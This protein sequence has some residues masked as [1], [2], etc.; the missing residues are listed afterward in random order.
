MK[1]IKQF[2][3]CTLYLILCTCLVSAQ[4]LNVQSGSVLYQFP[5][6]QAGEMLYSNATTLTING[7]E[8]NLGNIDKMYVDN[9]AVT[10]NTVTVTY[11]SNSANV[12]VA[13]NIAQYV[14]VTVSGAQVSIIQ[15]ENVDDNV[16]KISYTLS[17]SS[18]NGGFYHEG[19]YKID[20]VLN[21][22]T[23]T[24]P[25]GPAINIQNGKKINVTVKAGTTNTLVDGSNGDW[26][27][28]F[29]VK[30][31]TELKGG[32]VLNITGKTA[33]AFWGKE[34]LEMKNCTL[35]I[36]GA[37]GDGINVNQHFSMESGTLNISGV[38]DN[39]LQVSY[40]TDDND[41]I[42][43]EDD[44]TGAITITGGTIN[45]TTTA[46]GS[47]GIKA[48]GAI[49]IS[50]LA[51]ITSVTVKT[52][53][54]TL[55]ET[56]GTQRDTSVCVCIKSETAISISGGT[57]TLTSTGQGGR[58]MTCDKTIDITGGTITARAEGSNYTGSS[59]S[60]G[61]GGGP[62]GGGPGG[63]GFGNSSSNGKNAK[64]VKAKGAITISG[65]TLTVYS[66]SHEGM[67]SKSTITITDGIVNVQASDDA[68]NATGDFTISGGYVYGY[69]SSNDGLD[70]NGNF[71]IKGGVAI[72]FGAGG[73]ES[74]I[75]TGESRYLIIS[76]GYAFG[77]GG[78]VDA[79]ISSS[80]TQAYCSGSSSSGGGWGGGSS[81][82][83]SISGSYAVV[84]QGTTRLFAV[85]MPKTSYSGAVFCSA[86]EMTKKTSY[87]IG[88]SSSVSGTETNGFI[89][90]PTVTS[91][92]G[93]T[94]LTAK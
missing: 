33:N 66:A 69:S 75:D 76:G 72:G 80:S 88:G 11:N 62:G 54:G 74:G 70:A 5:A 87:S 81:S 82:T 15:S 19:S 3:L 51:N 13:G 7:K 84:S 1:I 93:G 6:S 68:I 16:G 61:G 52:T 29:R 2:I 39:G 71:Y 46:S 89:K 26:K 58:A 59:S 73:A 79:S 31:H 24:N 91:V 86:P 9:S 50:E 41:K 21:G 64:G 63:G 28:C 25:S 17:G 14:D 30:G 48:E 65:G 90:S 77:I 8:F 49:Y 78:R 55:L 23:L 22:V 56:S 44:N 32:G 38:G 43:V 45:I 94:S 42:I 67:E 53:G 37:V 85:K 35:N 40:E 18:S 10:D 20:L 60:W 12:I 92:S 47:K 36:L 4:T 83:I 27:G 57:L 34:F